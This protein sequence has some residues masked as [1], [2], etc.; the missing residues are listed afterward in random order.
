[1]DQ[2]GLNYCSEVKI[3]LIRRLAAVTVLSEHMEAQMINGEPVNASQICTLASTAVRISQRL[4][5]N[6][7][8]KNVTPTLSEYLQQREKLEAAK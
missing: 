5:L 8:P 1:V 2:G 6:R 3:G 4:G 7:L